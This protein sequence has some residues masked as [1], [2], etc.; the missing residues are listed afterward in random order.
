M[1]IWVQ[2]NLG[3]TQDARV[4]KT[5]IDLVEKKF[6]EQ[7]KEFN[8]YNIQFGWTWHVYYNSHQLCTSQTNWN[9]LQSQNLKL[10]FDLQKKIV[11]MFI[12]WNIQSLDVR[13]RNIKHTNLKANEV[14]TMLIG[15]LTLTHVT[16][17]VTLNV[18][19]SPTKELETQLP[20]L[21]IIKKCMTYDI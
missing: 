12:I 16:H 21:A 3:I 14:H 6:I 17:M 19:M 4:I 11:S 5:Y 1:E 2:I 13:K 9:C 8:M 10:L 7:A 15:L 20:I 18:H